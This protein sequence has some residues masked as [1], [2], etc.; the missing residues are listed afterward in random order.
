MDHEEI[1]ETES[2]SLLWK[3][4]KSASRDC[5]T[6]R[7]SNLFVALSIA[8]NFILSGVGV[9]YWIYNRDVRYSYLHGFKSDLGQE[10]PLTQ[11]FMPF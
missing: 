9:T 4:K 2:E 11:Y 3:T 6:I 1:S 7:I 10:K 8:L 5:G